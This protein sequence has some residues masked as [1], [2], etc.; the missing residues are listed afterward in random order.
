MPHCW[1]YA[2]TIRYYN[3]T[4]FDANPPDGCGEKASNF[5]CIQV[6]VTTF[7]IC[8]HYE[9]RHAKLLTAPKLQEL[10]RPKFRFKLQLL[11]AITIPNVIR[12]RWTVV[13]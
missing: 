11:G 13:Q 2:A 1:S 5:W 8:V 9:W 7:A 4:K 12:F 3:H 6:C 10:L